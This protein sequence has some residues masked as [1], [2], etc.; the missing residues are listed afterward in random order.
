LLAIEIAKKEQDKAEDIAKWFIKAYVENYIDESELRT[1]LR[2]LGYSAEQ[3]EF[4]IA[5]AN[6][7]KWYNSF[8]EKES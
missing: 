8:K 4:V 6:A 7:D 1:K 5:K 3:I 2:E